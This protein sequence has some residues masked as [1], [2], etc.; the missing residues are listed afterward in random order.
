MLRV[1]GLLLVGLLGANAL[2]EKSF[3]E[4]LCAVGRASLC[5]EAAL[6][7][8]RKSDFTRYYQYSEK[9][10]RGG[11]A[12]GCSNVGV[13]FEQGLFVQKDYAR[14]RGYYETACSKQS[15]I[16]CRNLGNL[17]LWGFGVPRDRALALRYLKQACDANLGEGCNDLARALPHAGSG[18]S[19]RARA[20]R[21]ALFVR[22]CDA[23][24]QFGCANLANE[25]AHLKNPTPAEAARAAELAS[26]GC[27]LEH[28]FSCFV[29]GYLLENGIGTS[30]N[31]PAARERYQFAC[32]HEVAASCLTLGLTLALG[33]G[34]TAIDLERAQHQF[35]R[36]CQLDEARAC[37]LLATATKS[38]N[39][40]S[41]SERQKK[42]AAYTARA[43][44]S[45]RESPYADE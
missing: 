2:L 6:N 22:A 21:R 41:D 17:H 29:F 45:R 34:G 40:L 11:S 10:C 13:A 38:D 32:D 24:N 39:S 7:A 43:E 37:D 42:S 33:A 28:P 15:A 4:L 30:R 36:A 26:K 18:D 23:G 35:E 16:A 25:L 3:P 1:G 31:L 19:E 5:A 27:L 20:E 9:S 14:A 12:T 8:Y 44:A